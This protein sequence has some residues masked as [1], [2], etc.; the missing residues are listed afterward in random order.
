[1]FS[2]VYLSQE[3]ADLLFGGITIVCGIFGTLAGG[4][5]L[6]VMDATI[7]NAFKVNL[8]YTGGYSCLSG[9]MMLITYSWYRINLFRCFLFMSLKTIIETVL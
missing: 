7:S 2:Y 9:F 6:D 8:R 4:F 1:M 3:N 5:I